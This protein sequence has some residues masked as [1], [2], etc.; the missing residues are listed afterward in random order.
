[1]DVGKGWYLFVVVGWTT[2]NRERERRGDGGGM[3]ETEEWYHVME[4]K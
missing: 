1:M 3:E 2:T 4:E